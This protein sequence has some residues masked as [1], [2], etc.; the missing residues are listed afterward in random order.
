M[1]NIEKLKK[2][3]TNEFIEDSVK[4][5]LQDMTISISPLLTKGGIGKSIT[6]IENKFN[7]EYTFYVKNGDGGKSHTINLVSHLDLNELELADDSEQEA[8]VLANIIFDE[9]KFVEKRIQEELVKINNTE[10]L[11][12]TVKEKVYEQ[13]NNNKTQDKLSLND[14]GLYVT[15][16]GFKY[17]NTPH[18]PEV[19]VTP[20]G[21]ETVVE[22]DEHKSTIKY[23]GKR[24]NCKVEKKPIEQI[25]LGSLTLQEKDGKLA[26]TDKNGSTRFI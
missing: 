21:L 22:D 6:V 3:L 23:K 24:I 11:I 12:K 17:M 4:Q 8:D 1:N 14:S 16:S 9:I 26:V 13:L 18:K 5:D 25:N 20:D 2:V 19:L 10:R 15:S 7:I